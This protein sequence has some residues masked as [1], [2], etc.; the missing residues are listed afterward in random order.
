MNSEMASVLILQGVFTMGLLLN[1]YNYY[2]MGGCYNPLR[3][4]LIVYNYDWFN[5]LHFDEDF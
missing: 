3:L 2:W 1:A 5:F 4:L